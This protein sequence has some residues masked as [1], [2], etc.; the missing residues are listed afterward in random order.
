MFQSFYSANCR[1]LIY[2]SVHAHTVDF[3]TKWLASY[4]QVVSEDFVSEFS[5]ARELNAPPILFQKRIN[6]EFEVRILYFGS[7]RWACKIDSQKS[8]TLSVDWRVEPTLA[9]KL[10]STFEVPDVLDCMC[11]ALLESLELKVGAFDLI[12][13][14]YGWVFLEVNSTPS[15]NWMNPFVEDKIQKGIALELA[16]LELA[17]EAG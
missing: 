17:Q 1:D 10:M 15:W 2:K 16:Q 8:N 7:R 4:T 13:T 9:Q 12:K 3:G 6:K 11:R 14:E 5:K